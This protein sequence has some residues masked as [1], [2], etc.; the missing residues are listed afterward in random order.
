MTMVDYNSDFDLIDDGD[1]EPYEKL[2]QKKL[3]LERTNFPLSLS[4]RDG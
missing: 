1:C 3:F 4:H 2:V